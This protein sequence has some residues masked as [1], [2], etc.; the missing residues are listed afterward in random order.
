MA[1]VAAGRRANVPMAVGAALLVAILFKFLGLEAF[2]IFLGLSGAAVAYQFVD[3]SASK[4]RLTEACERFDTPIADEFTSLE[5][6]TAHLERSNLETCQMIVAFD[7]TKSNTYK[8][9]RSFR[10][11]S[12]RVPNLHTILEGGAHMNPYQYVVSTLGRTLSA[13]D[14]DGKIAAFGFG[15]SVTKDRSVRSLDIDA[16]P[17]GPTVEYD[18]FE[19]VLA[20]YTALIKSGTVELSGP[21]SFAAIINRAI[22]IVREDGGYHILVIVTDGEVIDTHAT[23]AAIVAASHH[24]ISIIVVGVGDG[25][26]DTLETYDDTVAGRLFD[27]LQFVEW[28]KHV[29]GTKRALSQ[30]TVDAQF[31]LD[32]LQ[33]LPQQMHCIKKLGLMQRK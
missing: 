27:N 28:N 21:T 13:F 7:L 11:K 9:E 29:G 16:S 15:D 4:R 30:N 17:N 33:E 26:F 24:P 31:A 22:D 10:H 19:G 1:P 12:K 14:D 18:G 25:P 6:V 23:A 3:L 2:A 32:A 20:A 5:Q 8:G